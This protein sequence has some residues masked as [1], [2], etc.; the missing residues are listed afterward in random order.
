MLKVQIVG[1]GKGDVAKVTVGGELVI[2]PL[3]YDESKFVEL[4]EDNTAYNFYAPKSGHQF[5]ITGIR[6]KAD[7]QVSPTVDAVVIVYEATSLDTTVV[8]KVL[9]QEAMVQGDNMSLLSMHAKVNPGVWVNAK[10]TDDDIH[11]TIW[12]YY[13]PEL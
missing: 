9:H 2:A 5:I 13:I 6:A 4:A 12:G 7:R 11:M 3:G 10:T 8:S 1:G